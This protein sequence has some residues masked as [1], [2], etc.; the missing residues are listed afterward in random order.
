[1]GK[2]SA[3]S[4]GD[5][6][7]MGLTPGLGGSPGIGNGDPLQYSCCGE[8][9]GQRILVGYSPRDCRVGR[10]WA[11]THHIHSIYGWQLPRFKSQWC[12]FDPKARRPKTSEKLDV[13]V[14]VLRQ[15]KKP[16]SLCAGSQARGILI[17]SGE[18]QPFC[19]IQ[20]SGWLIEAH[21][22]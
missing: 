8:F 9:H 16:V 14:G 18:S 6:G 12:S 21:P 3:C 20:V 19:S 5:A 17:Y 22:H 11:H 7:N 15:E 1:M 10:D 4:A 2:E 13:S